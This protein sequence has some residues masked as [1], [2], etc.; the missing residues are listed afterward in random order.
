MKAF[1][2]SNMESTYWLVRQT[3][4]IVTFFGGLCLQQEYLTSRRLLS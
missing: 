2:L 3:I 1:R 4:S